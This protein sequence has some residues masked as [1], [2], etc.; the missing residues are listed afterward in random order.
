MYLLL[1][2]LVYNLIIMYHAPSMLCNKASFIP[3]VPLSQGTLTLDTFY[4]IVIY[5]VR[6]GEGWA[7]LGWAG[8]GWAGLVTADTNI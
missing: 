3:T 1:V 5:E 7:G 6:G 8:L 4:C 2:S